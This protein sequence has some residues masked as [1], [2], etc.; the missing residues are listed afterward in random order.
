MKLDTQVNC[1]FSTDG[2]DLSISVEK[3]IHY[4]IVWEMC[5]VNKL[6]VD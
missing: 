1:I 2:H 4:V 5:M 6:N 3:E